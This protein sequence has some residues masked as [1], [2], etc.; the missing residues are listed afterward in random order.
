MNILMISHHRRHKA[1]ARSHAMA[2]QLLKRG[3]SVSL[4][5][6]S[7]TRKFGVVESEWEGVHVI[8]TPNLLWG[9]MRSGWDLWGLLNRIHY[10]SIQKREYN[11]IHC[12]ETRPETIYPAL[13]YSKKK[14]IKV[15][16]DWNDWWG[17]G[18]LIDINRPKWYRLLFGKV[19]TFFEEQFRAK[20]A[21]LTIISRGLENRAINLG[22]QPENICYIPGGTFPDKFPMR[23]KNE[24]RSHIGFPLDIPIIGFSSA[25][26]HFDLELVLATLK[27]IAKKYPDVKLIVTG[28]VKTSVKQMV[29]DFEVENNVSLV[30]YVDFCDL[31][32][33]LGCADV[34]VLPFPDTPYNVGR[35]PNK[36]GDYL[37]LG[38]PT[39]S[40]PVGDI[41]KLF[42]EQE[43]GYLARWD[44]EEFA[45]KIISLIEDHETAKRF[46][47]NARQLA[48]TTYN[49][50]TLIL[51][52]EK[53]YERMVS[54]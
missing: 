16:S 51:K 21:G 46:G 22:V 53:F 50:K 19:E 30:G 36:I 11:L 13:Y 8:E 23:D 43:I 3:H 2:V 48:E 42:E 34:F 47:L 28:K 6:I 32:W 40:N 52:L 37:S 12:F 14:N 24:C 33:Y 54:G 31:P 1:V 27:I 7:E 9:R 10:L 29:I 20:V 5:V 4:M 38:R 17:R 39:V 25:E 45:E 18:G 44:A 41:K 35:W 26:S 15:I 49:W